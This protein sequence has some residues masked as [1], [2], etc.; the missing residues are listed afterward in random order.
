MINAILTGALIGLLAAMFYGR[1]KK[2]IDSNGNPCMCFFGPRYGMPLI[3]IFFFVEGLRKL[4]DPFYLKY[5]EN[6]FVIFGFSLFAALASIW[7]VPYKISLKN[8]VIKRT[9]PLIN[10]L[11]FN[12][13]DIKEIK[14]KNNNLVFHLN[15]GNKFVA[16]M[17]L[18]GREYFMNEARSLTNQPSRRS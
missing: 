9:A 1:R 16:N 14:D 11:S 18:S 13:T 8:G 3:A 10:P 15:N 17:L 12:V 5:P 7:F 4:D 2:E 6:L